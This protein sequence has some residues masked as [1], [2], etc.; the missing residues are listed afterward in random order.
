MKTKQGAALERKKFFADPA[1]VTTIVLLSVLLA[2]FILYPLAMLL[3]DSVHVQETNMV[4]LS[5]VLNGNAEIEYVGEGENRSV[6]V[7]DSKNNEN[8]IALTDLTNA[9]G[10]L[11][12]KNGR[13]IRDGD[14]IDPEKAYVKVKNDYWTAD[15]FPRIFKDYT[16]KNA[17]FNTLKLG[18]ITSLGAVVVGLLFAYVDCYV[19]VKSRI[20]K[21]MFDVVSTLPVVSPPFVLSLS[22]ILLFG[23]GGIITRELLKIYDSD[24]YGLKGIAIVQI[25][26]FFPVCY[27]ML[28]GLL[29]NIDPSMEEASRDMGASRWKVFRNCFFS[30][31]LKATQARC[32]ASMTGS[33]CFCASAFP[34]SV[35]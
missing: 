2:L 28:K 14:K 25:L 12:V 34:V 15:A 24:V 35:K 1:M 21:K 10:S 4:L 18:V 11:F 17:F 23:R 20:I 7:L 3:M 6:V 9:Y 5:D 29:K 22:M 32:S 16:F 26:T 8:E 33:K 31:S 30:A 27:M 13:V 19:S